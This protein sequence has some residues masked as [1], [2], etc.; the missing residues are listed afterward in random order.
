VGLRAQRLPSGVKSI[1]IGGLKVSYVQRGATD[2]EIASVEPRLEALSTSRLFNLL[3]ELKEAIRDA[4][5]HGYDLVLLKLLS[6][7]K[8]EIKRRVGEG[9]LEC[10]DQLQR[11][12]LHSDSVDEVREV[13]SRCLKEISRIPLKY[14]P[15]FREDIESTIRRIMSDIEYRRE[16]AMRILE[17]QV[18]GVVES[19]EKYPS[20]ADL[21]IEWFLESMDKSGQLA[22][23][24][25]EIADVLERF[26]KA[27]KLM[28]RE[29]TVR[30]RITPEM[31]EKIYAGDF[32]DIHRQVE[33]KIKELVS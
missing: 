30:I 25:L 22:Y 10:L 20:I 5:L 9:L 7:I 11:V 15:L 17:E 12:S 33:E 8:G 2:V 29:V 23:T 31:L 6:A 1:Q 24:H 13:A 16:L 18:R 14:L 19:A 21:T 26:V 28:N 4:A 32:T 3:R 27:V